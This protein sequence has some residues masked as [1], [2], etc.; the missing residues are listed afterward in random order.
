[1][2]STVEVPITIKNRNTPVFKSNYYEV[3]VDEDV[4]MFTSIL[5]VEASSPTGRKLIYSI[6][7]GNVYGEFDVDF[8]TGEWCIM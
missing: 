2:S 5:S 1:M 3:E 8:S 4:D 7:A 6:S